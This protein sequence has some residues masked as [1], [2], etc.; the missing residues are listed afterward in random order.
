MNKK[1]V[2]S[3]VVRY[4][5]YGLVALFFFWAI[6][7]HYFDYIFTESTTF[8]HLIKQHLQL[9]LVSSV[10][11]LL[12]AIPGGILVTRKQ[13]RRAEW[14]VSNTV[15]LGQTIPSLAV[16][17]LMISILGIG[18]QTAVFALFIYSLLPMYRNTVAGIDSIDENL[19]DAARGM[20]MKPIQI[21]FRI[22]L[23][24]AAYS[25]LAGVRTAIVLNIGTAALAY[26]VGG[27]GLGVWI[28]TGIQLFDNGYLISGAIPVTLLAIFV[29]YLLRLL[30]RLIVPEGSKPSQEL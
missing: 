2:I 6:S 5:V 28:F 23:P 16:L 15:N 10:L 24:N 27:G 26:V 9:V 14:V 29:D 8:W 20:G 12:I 11:A 30:E 25:I 18:F 4:S 1:R 3:L 13:F 21:L 17:A 19:I 22:E 7:N